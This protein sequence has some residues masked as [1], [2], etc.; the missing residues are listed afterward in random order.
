MLLRQGRLP[1]DSKPLQI[2]HQQAL[3]AF[4]MI[5]DL[6]LFAKPPAMHPER[7]P[8]ASLLHDV[9]QKVTRD[10][11]VRSPH[12]E[13]VL[14][15]GKSLGW[16]DADRTQLIVAM[17]ALCQNAME[18][19]GERG[20]LSVMAAGGCDRR[21][22]PELR[23]RVRDSGPGIPAEALPHVFDPFYSG[24]EAGRGLGFGLCKA[25][26]IVTDHGGRIWPDSVPRRGCKFTIC[27]PHYIPR[28]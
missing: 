24:R 7:I 27:L 8:V 26:R 1:E 22:R 17:D 12:L 10:A 14:R 13:V 21:G 5:A 20:V 18:A 6:A 2:I 19:M 11:A 25:W 16:I 23:L 4:Q 28:A 3:R 9:V 15:A